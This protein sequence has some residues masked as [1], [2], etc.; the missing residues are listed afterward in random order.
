MRGDQRAKVLGVCFSPMRGKETSRMSNAV[1]SAGALILLTD[2][3]HRLRLPYLK[4]RDLLLS[5][6]LRGIKRDGHWYV[7]C[8]SVAD[9][10]TP[11]NDGDMQRHVT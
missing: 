7:E 4:A 2:A 11:T 1:D 5:G 9:A 10:L 8:E 3:A 6:R